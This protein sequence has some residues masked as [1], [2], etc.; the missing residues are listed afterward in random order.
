MSNSDSR[1]S[2]RDA[3]VRLV[4]YDRRVFEAYERGIKR[5]G[6][7]EA[8]KDREIGHLSFKDTMVH[9]LNVHEAWLVA[10]AQERWD[11]FEDPSR[12]RA[13][14]RSWSD[15]R[16]YR[17]RV[18]RGIDD[19]MVGLTEA[20]LRRRVKVPWMAGRYTLQDAFFQ[21]SF[22][23]AHHIGEIIGAYWQMDR[24]PPQMM[25]IPTMLG[26]RAPVA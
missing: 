3:V 20:K 11:V 24:A 14:V 19:L 6:W 10:A 25:F 23:Q 18:W 9:I 8:T 16:R 5:L 13:N 17:M 26:M 22:E 7:A 2:A 21:S 15:L 12:K 1:L 4:T